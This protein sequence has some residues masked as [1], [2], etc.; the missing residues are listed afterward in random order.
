LADSKN[1]KLKKHLFQFIL[2]LLCS[3]NA[4]GNCS[5]PILECEV[6]EDATT[7]KSFSDVFN[8]PEFE[9]TNQ[10]NFGYTPSAYWMKITLPAACNGNEQYLVSN[11]NALDYIDF[12]LVENGIVTDSLKTGYLTP[13]ATRQSKTSRFVF[14]IPNVIVEESYVYVRIKKKEGTLRAELR[15]E[16]REEWLRYNLYEKKVVFFFLGVSFL[17]LVI[18]L[19]YYFF[20]RENIYLGFALFVF[21]LTMHQVS[22]L[23]YGTLY[24]WTDWHYMS[25]I[26]R[27]LFNVPMI[28]GLLLFSSSL[29]KIK[30]FCP[31]AFNKLY[32]IMIYLFL[33][34]LIFPFVPLPQYP[35]RNLIYFFHIITFIMALCLLVYASLK[36]ATKH[37]KPAYFFVS[38]EILIFLITILLWLRNLAIIEIDP[39]PENTYIYLAIVIMIMAMFSIVSYSNR[40][41][42]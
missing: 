29:L 21:S 42:S 18:S 14:K 36:A 33:G 39:L 41:K 16:D 15:I 3:I 7:L 31:P 4:S 30:E 34:E 40:I 2:L 20:Y 6:L 12:Y 13:I 8:N 35:Y 23:G 32:R 26:S 24:L 28:L 11:F 37:H 9:K 38:G 10:L 22:N 19:A 5:F 1:F 27:V 17:V 25:H